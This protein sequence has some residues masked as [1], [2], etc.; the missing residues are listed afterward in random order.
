ME[1]SAHIQPL[2]SAPANVLPIVRRDPLHVAVDPRLVSCLILAAE[3]L[4]DR[5]RYRAYALDVQFASAMS[6]A[7]TRAPVIAPPVSVD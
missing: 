4:I 1:P 7:D 2:C 6:M 3:Q 5:P